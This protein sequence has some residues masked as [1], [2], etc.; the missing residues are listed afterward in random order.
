[1]PSGLGDR[2]FSLTLDDGDG[3][4]NGGDSAATVSFT[5]TVTQNPPVISGL[6]G[7]SR[8]YVKGVALVLDDGYNAAVTDSDSPNFNTG[9]L[10]VSISSG[11]Q[12]TEDFLLI[13]TSGS[14]S[15]SAGLII[16]SNV[17]VDGITIGIVSST[18]SNGNN[19]VITFNANSTHARVNSLLRAIEYYNSNSVSPSIL[20][21]QIDF[22]IQDASG[23]GSAVSE[24]S[25]VEVILNNKPTTTG[26]PDLQVASNAGEFKH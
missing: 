26:I 17:D 21:R 24:I 5:V 15:L 13:N 10:T 6:D 14:V 1:M 16:G 12:P 22:S 3:N 19:L 11:L 18:G 23:V 4:L 9:N 20:A 7:D 25:R 2:I 8:N